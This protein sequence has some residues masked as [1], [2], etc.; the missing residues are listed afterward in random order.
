MFEPGQRVRVRDSS[1]WREGATGKIVESDSCYWWGSR[2]AED[3]NIDLE[4]G[5]R[6]WAVR[7]DEPEKDRRDGGL[8][9][10]ADVEDY[11]LVAEG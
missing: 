5:G 10:R 8:F 7:F 11:S 2:S 4:G 9:D 1:R 3:E 6:T